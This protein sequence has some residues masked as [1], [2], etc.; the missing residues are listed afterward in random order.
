MPGRVGPGQFERFRRRIKGGNRREGT[1]K[2]QRDRQATAA[3]AEVQ[4]SCWWRVDGG[5]RGGSRELSEEAPA[6][7]GEHF[8]LGAGDQHV[9]ID[10]NPQAAKRSRTN[11]LLQRFALAAAFD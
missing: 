10:G 3:S 7:L 6:F 2:S 4:G 11:D 9:P 8:G 5:G 1:V